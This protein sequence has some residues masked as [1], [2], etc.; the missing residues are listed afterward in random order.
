MCCAGCA[1]VAQAIVD[2]GLAEYYTHR[3]ALPESPANSSAALPE[4]L[5]KLGL[6]DHPDV[7]KT[8]VRAVG[9]AGAGQEREAALIL[10][11]ITC[12]A[13]IWLNE[14]HLRKLRGVTA[15]DVNYATR[16][17]RVRWDMRET[18]LSTILKA[19][20]DI[21]YRAHP[22]DVGRSEEVAQRERKTALWRVFVAGFGMM[23]VMM[24]AIPGYLAEVGGDMSFDIAQLMRWSSLVLT[25]PVVLY[26]AAPFFRNA[27]RDLKL[28]RVGMDVPVAIGVGA[29]FAASAW[30]TVSGVGEV[31]F[32]S[33]TMFVFFLLTGRYFE[34]MARQRAA[35]GVEA[36]ALAIPA[37][38]N[39]YRTWPATAVD[40]CAV[41]DLHIDDVVLVRPGEVVPAD[42]TVIDGETQV[43][44]SLLTGESRP[45]L[46]RVGDTLVGGS[47]NVASHVS[48]RIT[49]VGENTRLATIARL[50]ERASSE[51]P[52][53]VVLADR[54][55]GHFVGVLLIMAVIT[56]GVW[57]WIEPS[58]MLGVFV[59]VLVV[60]CPC[61]LSLAT[62]TA[63]TVGTGALAA[64]GLLVTR[65]HAIETLARADRVV[66]DKTG[67]LTE[68]QFSLLQVI[69]L[70]GTADD[71]CRVAA[72]LEHGSEHPIGRLLRQGAAAGHPEVVVD[73]SRVV[74]GAGIEGCID[75]RRWRIG[76]PDFVGALHGQ[77][78]AAEIVPQV[79]A[80][81]TAI[82]LGDED[83][84][85]AIFLLGDTLRADARTAIHSL[86]DAGLATFLLSG[87]AAPAVQRVA[88]GVGIDPQKA[89]WSARSPEQ[90]HEVI[91]AMQAEGH[92]V[93][94]VG[95]GIND[96]PVLAQA[97]VS[98]AMAGGADLARSHADVVLLGER[99]MALPEG[100]VLARRTM[101]IVRQNLYWSALY[102]AS[103]VP[104]AMV[105]WVTPWMAGIGMAGS[106]L[107]VVL[108]AL[109]L[110]A[111]GKQR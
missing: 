80:G 100:I 90:K 31:Y 4:A 93:V 94:M 84:W 57:W 77:P 97:Q 98:V 66:F 75:G 13:C 36:V 3:G 101:R 25:T 44:E 1:A 59:A 78:L 12:S 20:A 52:Q 73:E 102:N 82:A 88:I 71:A 108:N 83:G 68:G 85:H 105:G 38:A 104:L 37:L 27:W 81:E 70:R 107:L 35:R 110:Q 79:G 30:A 47:V 22:Y 92:V 34:L 46:K 6:F 74:A 21:G 28:R 63:L 15:V 106:S 39:R 11:G 109:R 26:S 61:A 64:R 67:T 17:A 72:A 69:P 41:A 23:Q 45:V 56:A 76:S 40:A 55:A 103:A 62:P 91:K 58:Q 32:D 5:A 18:Q 96:A 50:M 87:D 42:G 95:D 10:E 51:K 19:I 7:Q 24:Y 43:D 49:L 14:T 54:I 16:R 60:S 8:F 86:N 9:V 89:A 2:N 53:I 111:H 48:M 65:G 99:L 33:V 29:A